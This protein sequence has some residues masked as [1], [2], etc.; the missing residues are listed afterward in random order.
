MFND[1]N[2]SSYEYTLD[3]QELSA[4]D[5]VASSYSLDLTT[6]TNYQEL[7]TKLGNNKVTVMIEFTRSYDNSNDTIYLLYD[8]YI[9]VI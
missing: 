2:E 9:P 3:I 4:V 8:K 7:L 6:L 5:F 1:E